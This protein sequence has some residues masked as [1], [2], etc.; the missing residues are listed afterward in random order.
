MAVPRGK[1]IY[2]RDPDFYP[3]SDPGAYAQQME[4]DFICLHHFASSDA[5]IE[6]ARDRG[7]QVWLWSG[8]ESWSA[9]NWEPTLRALSGRAAFMGLS[10]FVADPESGWQG[11]QAERIRLG[12]S[13]QAATQITSVGVTS[14]PSWYIQDVA[15]HAPSVWGSPQLYGIVSPGTP[16]ELRARGM[17]WAK[18]MPTI[19]S[20]AAWSRSPVEQESYLQA[21]SDAPGAILWQAPS[22]SGNIQPQP[23]TPGFTVLRQWQPTRTRA[24]DFVAV[25]ARRAALP[26]SPGRS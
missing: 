10:G 17:R 16:Q 19:P 15:E 13:L 2:A 5:H 9:D 20:L 11:R 4:C 26:F 3:G 6:R 23:G 18:L 7:L 8:P 25:A 1:G 24:R 12:K 22:H 14:Y 21:F